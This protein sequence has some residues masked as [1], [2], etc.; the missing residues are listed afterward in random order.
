MKQIAV[1]FVV[2][3]S[4]FASALA[5]PKNSWLQAMPTERWPG[6]D[7]PRLD[8]LSLTEILASK[9]QGAEERLAKRSIVELKEE[10]EISHF[11]PRAFSCRSGER[12]YLVRALY[13]YG[14]RGHW[15]VLL[16]GSDVV[17]RNSALGPPAKAYRS[18]LVLCLKKQPRNVFVEVTG[19]M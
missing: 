13:E 1:A 8:E 10:Y 15:E 17:V 9:L 7:V 14:H 12:A 19:A 11:A 2:L 6:G 18:A 4:L 16:I 5:T 3:N